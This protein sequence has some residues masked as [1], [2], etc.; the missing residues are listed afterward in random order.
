[1]KW[2]VAR[3]REQ[4]THS[5]VLLA[6][7]AFFASRAAGVDL[8]A[9]TQGGGELLTAIAVASAAAKVLLPEAPPAPPP[10]LSEAAEKG[11]ERLGAAL[12]ERKP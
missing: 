11:L 2:I 12:E 4:T 6:V 3:L 1:M 7:I 9:L 10:V 8:I 5:A